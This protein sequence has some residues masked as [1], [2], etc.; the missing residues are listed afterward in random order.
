METGNDNRIAVID[1]RMPFWSLVVLMV[2]AA[3]AS[4]P[5]LIIL[6][7]IG[8]AISAVVAGIFGGLSDMGSLLNG[9]H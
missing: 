2:K 4:I 9:L 3:I 7:V 8:A 6:V 5:A 1:V